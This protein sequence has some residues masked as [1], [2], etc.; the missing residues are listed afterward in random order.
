MR[1]AP[2]AL[3][4]APCA[5]PY[6]L[7]AETQLV[8]EL[9]VLREVGALQ[10]LQQAAAAA[11]HL[12]QAALPVKVLGVDPEVLGEAVDPLGEQRHLNP[13]GPGVP[14]VL[15]VLPDRRRLV[16]HQS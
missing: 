10:V 3:P 7:M 13:A 6:L 16:V 2:R 11:D 9:P 8:D 5:T 1:R 12:Q 15:P 14:I 4:G